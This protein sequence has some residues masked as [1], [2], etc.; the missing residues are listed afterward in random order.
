MS[1][2]I[3]SDP[4]QAHE[5]L[6]APAGIGALTVRAVLLT[7]G[8]T[9]ATYIGI[10]RLGYVRI[11]WVPYIVPP[12]PAILFLLILVGLNAGLWALWRSGRMPRLLAPFSRGEL[13]VVY[14]ALAASLAMERAGYILHYLMF[15]KYYGTDVDGYREL[16]QYY[17][18]FYIPH[19]TWVVEGFFEG[20]AS[21]R[22][23]WDLWWGPLGWWTLF[24]LVLTFTVL[25]L[26]AIFRKQWSENERLTYPM[27]FLPLEIT[28]GFSGSSPAKSFFTDPVMWLGFGVAAL[29]N[30][31]N[32][33]HAFYPA[34]PQIEKYM[35]VA[36][37][38][39]EG[40]LRYLRPMNF[41]LALEVWGLAYLMSGEVLLTAFGSYFF[42]KLVKITGR[43][44]GYRGAGFP[45]YQEVSAGSCI[46]FTTFMLWAAR[47]HLRRVWRSILQ[48]AREYD[49]AEP[50]SYRAQTVG[51]VGGT[52]AMMWMLNHAGIRVGPLLAYFITLWMFVLVAARIRAEAGPPVLWTH[53]YGFDTVV[54]VHLL[55]NRWLRG[56]GSPQ[57]MVLYYAL[58]WIGRTVLAHSAGQAFIDGLKLPDY[59][60]ARRSSFAWLMLAACLVALGLTFWYHLDVGYK[61]GQGLIGAKTGRAG[62]SWALNWSRGNYRLLDQALANPQGP[63]WTRVGFYGAG[64]ALTAIVTYAR[65]LISNFP[66]HPLGIIMGT[67]YN[68]WSPY[69]GPFLGAWIAQRLTLRY[70]SLP[71]YRRVVPAFLGLFFGHVLIGGIVWRIFI[72]YFIDPVISFRYYLNLGG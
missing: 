72:N 13:L 52:V 71:A 24:C 32:I 26:V 25:C 2:V 31:I 9:F 6:P 68:D 41:S 42:M 46:A 58:F 51:F 18:D 37:G 1:H 43:S 48:G 21:G 30:I 8:L 65:M 63:D 57:S 66:F 11:C 49:R 5:R 47:P 69:W 28:G 33:I 20:T 54:P 7:V 38:I 23:P 50:M 17:P 3:Q 35:P 53:P 60:R 55:G 16:F 59:V 19:D 61:Y 14:A 10:T 62:R 39:T 12:A 15:P 44:L 34:F 45:F 56:T 4:Q 70:G 64:F 29:F 40:P 36:A 27:L 67:L 22:V